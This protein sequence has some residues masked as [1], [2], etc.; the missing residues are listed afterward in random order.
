M[1]FR[2][3][4]SRAFFRSSC[5]QLSCSAREIIE[6]Q[7]GH[8]LPPSSEILKLTNRPST[9]QNQAIK[10]LF[11]RLTMLYIDIYI[12]SFLLKSFCRLSG[13]QRTWQARAKTKSTICNIM[14]ILCQKC[15]K[16]NNRFIW[17]KSFA[18][19]R[20]EVIFNSSLN[21]RSPTCYRSV[22]NYNRFKLFHFRFL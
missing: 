9:S 7:T 10:E 19:L 15:R 20:L 1:S 5:V 18:R 22:I 13:D 8:L 21:R 4:L 2:H 12:D 17:L 3:I 14:A 6:R 11:C 16:R